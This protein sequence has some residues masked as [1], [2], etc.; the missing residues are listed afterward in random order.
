MIRLALF[1][2][3]LPAAL[4][5]G[6][7]SGSILLFALILAAGWLAKPDAETMKALRVIVTLKD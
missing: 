7:L 3:S 4:L 6:A 2:V 1:L 5:A